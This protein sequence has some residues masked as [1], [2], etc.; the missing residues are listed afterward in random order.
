M[1][2]AGGGGGATRNDSLCNGFLSYFKTRF[3]FYSILS[4][5]MGALQLATEEINY[6]PTFSA[7]PAA[8]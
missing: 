2:Q 7:D 5:Y 8:V 1:F 6:F 3:C 4:G